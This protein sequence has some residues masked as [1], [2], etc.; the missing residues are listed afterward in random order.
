MKKYEV[1]YII[2]ESVDAE[3]R[4][5]L[6]E[7]LAKIITDNGGTV[8]KTDEWGMREFAYQ[9]DDMKKGYYVVVKFEADKDCV[10]EYDRLMRIN[11]SVVRFMI[12]VDEAPVQEG[13]K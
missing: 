2:N 6:I 10:K 3:K 13:R 9:I 11:A 4:A 7:T 1:M 12:T 8:N 5:E